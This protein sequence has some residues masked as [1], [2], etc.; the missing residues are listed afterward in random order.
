VVRR[1][2]AGKLGTAIIQEKKLN[3]KTL[4]VYGRGWRNLEAQEAKRGG[5]IG[6]K[7][8]RTGFLGG[9]AIHSVNGRSGGESPK[10]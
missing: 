6:G 1:H 8:F 9:A 4:K 3:R 7:G 5:K 2:Q 10:Q